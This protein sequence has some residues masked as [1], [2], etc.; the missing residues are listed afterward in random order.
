MPD[1]ESFR[2][3]YTR[4]AN[5][6]FIVGSPQDCL[7]ALLPWRDELGVNHFVLRAEWAGMPVEDARAS[8]ELLA[9]E[10]AAALRT[11]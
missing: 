2:I 1:E 8:I 10:L 3:D 5:D 11:P 6:R 9:R 7:D 4:L